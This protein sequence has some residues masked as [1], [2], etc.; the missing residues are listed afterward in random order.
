MNESLC[1]PS[2]VSSS[3]AR[4]E[5]NPINLQKAL[6]KAEF[7]TTPVDINDFRE[8]Y[9]KGYIIAK[10]FNAYIYP[11]N[12]SSIDA[13]YMPRFFLK[14]YIEFES[15]NLGKDGK[16]IKNTQIFTLPVDYESITDA[17]PYEKHNL[18]TRDHLLLDQY[19]GIVYATS[20]TIYAKKIVIKTN[21]ITT[22]GAKVRIIA[23][24]E[25]IVKPN[26]IIS[27]DIE[28]IITKNPFQQIHPQPAKNSSYMGNFCTNQISG[29]QYQAKNLAT[30]VKP[31]NSK[32]PVSKSYKSSF[33]T[34]IYPNP[35]N[36]AFTVEIPENK[37]L[38]SL[39]LTDITGKIIL[40]KTI[41]AGQT[42]TQ[43]ETIG[44]ANGIYMLIIKTDENQSTKKII[45][46]NPY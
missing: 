16:P 44:L 2:L 21:L 36:G 27:P 26:A 18:I 24:E 8:L 31:T 20:Q 42:T 13:G 40:S 11:I 22:G 3:S 29:L 5:R 46:N 28:L 17:F 12:S 23:S 9:F 30:S 10:D 37:S 7:I 41:A 14:Y 6:D 35:N 34:S 45:I 1:P 43:I 25:I 39:V 15:S 38:V 33:N 4:K 32:D 19:G